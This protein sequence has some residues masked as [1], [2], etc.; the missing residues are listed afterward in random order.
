MSRR[1]ARRSS[2][3]QAPHTHCSEGWASPSKGEPYLGAGMYRCGPA[4]TASHSLSESHTHH[5]RLART[6][7]CALPHRAAITRVPPDALAPA[8]T[9]MR[10]THCTR[11]THTPQLRRRRHL[12]LLRRRLGRLWRRRRRRLVVVGRQNRRLPALRAS[13]VVQGGDGDAAAKVPP[14]VQ[15]SRRLRRRPHCRLLRGCRQ[16][17][18]H[19]QA[20]CTSR[21]TPAKC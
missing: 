18:A 12:G 9:S 10:R 2:H 7:A 19:Q 11:R 6:P 1:S 16:R 3:T 8:A 15:R 20:R 21:S 14:A 4:A 5:R 17:A 13:Q